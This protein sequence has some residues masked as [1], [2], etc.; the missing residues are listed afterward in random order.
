[1]SLRLGPLELFAKGEELHGTL[2]GHEFKIEHIANDKY[3]AR[4]DYKPLDGIEMMMYGDWIDVSE[5]WFLAVRMKD[6]E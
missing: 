2:A 1:M 6:S 4:S 5:F 3:L